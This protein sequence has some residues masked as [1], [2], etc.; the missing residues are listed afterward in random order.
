VSEPRLRA[1]EC[2]VKGQEWKTVVHHLS[3]GKAKYRYLLQIRDAWEHV[4]FKD[5]TCRTLGPPRDTE[6][7]QRTVAYRGVDLHMGDRVKVGDS[8]GYIAGTNSSANFDVVF[9]TG[10]YAGNVLNCHPIAIEKLNEQKIF[11]AAK[12]SGPRCRRRIDAVGEP[13][14]HEQTAGGAGSVGTEAETGLHGAG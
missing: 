13:G 9:I 8:I 11:P 4:T 12:T 14:Q 1:Y 5:I 3:A 2:G 10:K 6:D 7:L